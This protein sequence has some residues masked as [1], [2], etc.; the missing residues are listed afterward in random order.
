MAGAAQKTVT[1][2]D[3]GLTAQGACDA[4]VNAITIDSRDVMPGALFGA[5]PGSNVHGAAYIGTALE[6]GAAAILTDR[7][8]AELAA[9]VLAD[10]SACL[11]ISEDPRQTLAQTAALFFGAQPEV[12]VAVTGTNGKTS[13]STFCRQ[14]WT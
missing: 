9:D 1:L 13:V 3:L 11:I 2:S 6:N 14:I 8:G 7:A 10:S 4:R 5:M 12:A